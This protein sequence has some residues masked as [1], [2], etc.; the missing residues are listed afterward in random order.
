MKIKIK[1]ISGGILRG[2][3]SVREIIRLLG[4][5]GKGIGIIGLNKKVG[6]K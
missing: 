5:I 6:E 2:K 1:F 3:M 4:K